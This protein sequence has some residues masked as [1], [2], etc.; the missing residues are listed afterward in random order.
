MKEP[1]FTEGPWKASMGF[2]DLANAMPD[3]CY[4]QDICGKSVC[5]IWR[6]MGFANAS[7]IAAA[8][9]MYGL[10]RRIHSDAFETLD[11]TGNA[12]VVI[13]SDLI[14]EINLLLAKARGEE[15]GK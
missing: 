9:E 1:E 6:T 15:E 13:S 11:E 4:V 2:P 12:V 10:L 8:P 5:L 14:E 3:R 7:L